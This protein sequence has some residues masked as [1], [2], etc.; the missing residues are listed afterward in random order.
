MICGAGITKD[1]E[2]TLLALQCLM[3]A[4]RNE[5][6]RK[7]LKR[8]TAGELWMKTESM[9]SGKAAQDDG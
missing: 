9:K 1:T 5:R 3:P 7:W 4:R 2:I 6:S 8:E